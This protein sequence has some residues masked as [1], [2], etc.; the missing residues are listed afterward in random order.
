MIRPPKMALLVS[1]HSLHQCLLHVHP[2]QVTD[3]ATYSTD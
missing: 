1:V 3:L 2:T